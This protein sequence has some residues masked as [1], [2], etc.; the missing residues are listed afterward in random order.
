MRFLIIALGITTFLIAFIYSIGKND[1]KYP[2]LLAEEEDTYFMLAVDKYEQD[3]NNKSILKGNEELRTV[4]NL[5]NSIPGFK[6]VRNVEVP[7]LTITN[8]EYVQEMYPELVVEHSPA[9]MVFDNKEMIFKSYDMKE[10]RE[11]LRELR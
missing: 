1:F 4:I 8:L 3:K 11:F 7:V 6:L 9:V 10:V 2:E 5:T